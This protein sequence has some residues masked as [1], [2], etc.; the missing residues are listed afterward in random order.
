MMEAPQQRIKY[1]TQKLGMEQYTKSGY[2]SQT[3]LYYYNVAIRWKVA[4]DYMFRP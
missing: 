1:L 2:S 4:N 3:Q